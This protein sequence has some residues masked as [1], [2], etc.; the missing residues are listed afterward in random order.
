MQEREAEKC[1]CPGCVSRGS[2]G[3]SALPQLAVGLADAFV[4]GVLSPA[5]SLT[6]FY[7][8]LRCFLPSCFSCASRGLE[9]TGTA[10]KRGQ[11]AFPF[12]VDSKRLPV[13]VLIDFSNPRTMSKRVFGFQTHAWTVLGCWLPLSCG[14]GTRW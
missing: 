3:C 10:D 5:P 11:V 13:S 6:R 8:R 7:R 9:S 2:F 4:G 12:F 14:A 1:S